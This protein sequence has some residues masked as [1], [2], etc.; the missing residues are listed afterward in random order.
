[1][2][3][4]EHVIKQKNQEIETQARQMQV[5]SH[6]N[7]QLERD[8]QRVSILL[9]DSDALCLEKDRQLALMEKRMA[10]LKR[11]MERREQDLRAKQDED[12]EN[13]QIMINCV[14]TKAVE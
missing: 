9:Q 5:L 10:K 11:D 3:D 12:K 6:Q 2:R 4:Y 13:L 7:A 8:L 14:Q 1:M